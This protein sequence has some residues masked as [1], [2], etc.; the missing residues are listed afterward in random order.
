M[1]RLPAS[2]CLIDG[3][4]SES[5]SS[6]RWHA[7]Y[8]QGW[9]MS[10][11]REKRRM[12]SFIFFFF[13]SRR[14]HTRYWRTGVQTCALPIS[15]SGLVPHVLHMTAT[16]IPRTLRLASFG[17]LDVTVLRELPKGRQPI[18]THVAGGEHERE[19]AY[20]RIREELRSGRQ[21]FVVCPLVAESEALAARAATAEYERLR[22]T[23]FKDFEV[24]L[25]RSE[26]HT[27]ELK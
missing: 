13:P 18:E 27:S 11:F 15:P 8:L 23:E 21:A 1:R 14:R 16:P 20:E 3:K 19:R 17:A 9:G 2:P 10:A 24:V 26:E 7:S 25:L 12:A 4:I 6:K 5:H 22:T